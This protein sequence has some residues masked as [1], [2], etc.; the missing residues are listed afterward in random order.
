MESMNTKESYIFTDKEL[1]KEAAEYQ[2]KMFGVRA[3]VIPTAMERAPFI[4]TTNIS[5]EIHE[6]PIYIAE[7]PND[8]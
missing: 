4:V 3:A 2:A 8:D 7:P 5:R 6:K 1:A